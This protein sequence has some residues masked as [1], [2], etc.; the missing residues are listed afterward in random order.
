[1]VN[2]VI[3]SY[4]E[5]VKQKFPLCGVAQYPTG[6]NVTIL[7][8]WEHGK[9]W[10]EL[11]LLLDNNISAKQF[12]DAQPDLTEWENEIT[13]RMENNGCLPTIK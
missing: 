6:G 1:M 2:T 13:T 4:T 10:F 7:V 5:R 9:D 11:P 8:G 12:S 3:E